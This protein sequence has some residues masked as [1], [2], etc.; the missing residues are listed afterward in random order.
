MPKE[1]TIGS[2][3][4]LPCLKCGELIDIDS[5]E[6]HHYC[7]KKGTKWLDKQDHAM[8]LL[9]GGIMYDMKTK[10]AVKVL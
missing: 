6:D 2:G 3:N 5:V 8:V 4:I 1:I 10:K 7:N 9:P